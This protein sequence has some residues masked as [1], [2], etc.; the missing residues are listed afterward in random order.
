MT[1]VIPAYGSSTLADV[2]PS[3]AARLGVPGHE[4]VLG[5]PEAQRYVVL[6]VDGL[7]W[8]ITQGSLAKAGFLA[9]LITG[10]PR[11]TAGVPSTTVTSLTSLGTG[12]APGQHGVAGFSFRD[13]GSQHTLNALLWGST[14][15]PLT[16]QPRNTL[17]EQCVQAGVAATRVLP[18]K[19]EGSGLTV[20]G[21][22]GGHFVAQDDDDQAR[23]DAVRA[24][25]VA[26]DRTLVYHYIRELDH[27]GHTLGVASPQW[28]RRLGLVARFVARLRDALPADVVL[29]VTGDHGMVDVPGHHR[30]IAED[31]PTLMAG[32]DLLAGEARFRQL[33]TSD[34][35]GVAERWA[36]RF[37][38]RA[39]VRTRAQAAAE[40]WFGELDSRV[41]A[42]FGDVVVAMRTDWGVLTT[43]FP[44]EHSLV[45][46]HGSL[47]EAEMVVPLLV[48]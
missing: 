48:A 44:K 29:L 9:E 1:P 38:D 25:A 3:V 32:V 10:A 12:L 34:P 42:R 27:T 7:G 41:A 5:L 17:F 40:G 45:G 21:L 28:Q 19:F 15:D 39:W 37:G 47:T 33:Y 6:L 8:N 30:V 2:L 35:E 24:G 31:D 4:D 20:A 22:R 23:V 16:F 13:P 36:N 11:L 43:T 18:Q 14:P 46:M 26:G